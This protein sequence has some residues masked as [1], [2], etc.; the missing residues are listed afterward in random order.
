M[1]SLRQ[2]LGLDSAPTPEPGHAE[3]L[4]AIVDSL[5][6]LEPERAKYLAAFAYLLG[7]VARADHD[8]SAEETATMERLVREKG[9]L[10]EEHAILVVQVARINNLH[11]GGT[12]D[13]LVAR[14]FGRV[15]SY[16]ERLA[17]LDCLFAVSSAD[18]GVATIEDNEIRRISRELKIEHADYIAIRSRYR[19]HLNVLKPDE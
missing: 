18:E 2:W 10:V 7:R 1:R 19:Q 6:R 12:A 3:A 16:P 4:R 11:F 9:G 15:A 14:E 8:V 13:F 17:L 5:D